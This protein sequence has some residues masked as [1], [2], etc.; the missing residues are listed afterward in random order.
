MGNAAGILSWARIG[1]C[2]RTCHCPDKSRRQPGNARN[3]PRACASHRGC[4]VAGPVCHGNGFEKSK[5]GSRSYDAGLCPPACSSSEAVQR[6]FC[7]PGERWTGRGWRRAVKTAGILTMKIVTPLWN[8]ILSR[9]FARFA[10]TCGSLCRSASDHPSIRQPSMRVARWQAVGLPL[11]FMPSTSR[12]S[13]PSHA[14]APRNRA[15]CRS[16]NRDPHTGRRG[17]W[18]LPLPSERDELRPTQ[19]R[20]SC[21]VRPI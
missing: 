21:Q 13:W 6:A 14:S 2:W 9:P 19:H 15:S 12:P 7:Q 3:L 5:R 17:R 11:S 20:A 16:C 1:L 4:S 18:M 8:D 10:I